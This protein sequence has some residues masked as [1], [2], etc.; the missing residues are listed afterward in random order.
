MRIYRHLTNLPWRKVKKVR[1]ELYSDVHVDSAYLSADDYFEL[2]PVAS[3]AGVAIDS[4]PY[5]D[6]SDYYEEDCW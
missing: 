1:N 2:C 4:T 5:M 6:D 3:I